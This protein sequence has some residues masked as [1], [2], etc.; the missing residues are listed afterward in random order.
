MHKEYNC[1]NQQQNAFVDSCDSN[2]IPFEPLEKHP[3]LK[4]SYFASG[5]STNL[6]F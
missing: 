5:I 2:N 1:H 6:S 4:S 3:G